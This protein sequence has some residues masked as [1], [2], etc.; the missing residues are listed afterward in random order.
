MTHEDDKAALTQTRLF[1]PVILFPLVI[2]NSHTRCF[3]GR[4]WLAGIKAGFSFARLSLTDSLLHCRWLLT[5]WPI[6]AVELQ[7][8]ETVEAIAEKPG[9]ISVSFG[10]AEFGVF[11][12]FFLSGE[13]RGT[14]QRVILNTDDAE[15]WLAE[16]RRRVKS[17]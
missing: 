5:Q 15:T 16:L 10:Q 6:F 11:T 8:I 9:L 1:W 17:H 14:R 13:P 7:E 12:R 2:D 3:T 4:C